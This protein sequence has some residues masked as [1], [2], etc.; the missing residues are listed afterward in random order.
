MSVDMGGI[1]SLNKGFL[2][3]W[4]FFGDAG[5]LNAVFSKWKTTLEAGYCILV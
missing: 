5:N 3:F 2:V 4:V 1:V